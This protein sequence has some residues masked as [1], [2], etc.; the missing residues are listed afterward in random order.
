MA[1]S[2]GMVI[3]ESFTAAVD[4]SAYQ[5]MFVAAGSVV[6]EVAAATAGSIPCPLGILQNDPKAGQTA[7]VRLFGLSKLSACGAVI[8]GAASA[9]NHGHWMTCGSNSK[10]YGANADIAQA[11][12]LDSI[13]SAAATTATVFLVGP[14]TVVGSRY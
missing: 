6:G 3:D 1:T 7:H 5:Y 12:L 10:G 9:L 8:T 11:V 13:A 14:G 4:L 2:G